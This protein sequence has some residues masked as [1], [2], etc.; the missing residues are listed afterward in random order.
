MFNA[1]QKEIE[2]I[3][4]SG[5]L[6][7]KFQYKVK[8][9]Q[10]IYDLNSGTIKYSI[11]CVNEHTTILVPVTKE[12]YCSLSEGDYVFINYDEYMREIGSKLIEGRCN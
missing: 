7:K 11:S 2:R 5:V 12:V 1:Q 4:N 6:H 3:V 8:S 10:Q 9:H